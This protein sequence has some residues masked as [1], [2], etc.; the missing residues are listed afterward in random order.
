MGCCFIMCEKMN[1]CLNI[2]PSVSRPFFNIIPMLSPLFGTFLDCEPVFV[3]KL[4]P[5]PRVLSPLKLC[6]QPR[7]STK[8]ILSLLKNEHFSKSPKM[9]KKSSL[10]LIPSVSASVTFIVLKTRKRFYIEFKPKCTFVSLH[11]NC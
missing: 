2:I 1:L 3:T 4:Q 5:P 10:N 6:N 8:M 7:K 9:F 11:K